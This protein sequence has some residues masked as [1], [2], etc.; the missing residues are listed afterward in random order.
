[1]IERAKI[2]IIEDESIVAEDLKEVLEK[3]GYIVPAILSSG[4]EALAVV[5]T[6]HPDLILMD[7]SLSGRLDGIETAKRIHEKYNIP[8]IYLTSY[9]SDGY[10][11]S[12]K[13]T[14][15]YGYIVK[16]FDP[17]SIS[18]TIEIALHKH[19]I[20]TRNKISLD[21][22]RF[23]AEYTSSWEMW[24][25][26]SGSPL[27]ISPSCERITGY[28]P[29]EIIAHPRLLQDMVFS[30]DRHIY[31]DHVACAVCSPNQCDRVNFRIVTRSGDVRWIG[32]SCV[33]IRDKQGAV[34]GKRISNADITSEQ[35]Q[36]HDFALAFQESNERFLLLTETMADTI[37][38]VY[39]EA[40][41]LEYINRKGASL[42]GKNPEELLN[43]KIPDL[44]EPKIAKNAENILESF[45]TTGKPAFVEHSYIRCPGDELFFETWLFSLDQ[46]SKK[47][48][49]VWGLM[50]DISDKKRAEKDLLE[51]LKEKDVMLKEIHH[52]V[53]N[54]LQQ[55]ASLLYLQEI[56]GNN[57]DIVTALHESR[58]RIFS[59]ALV[60]EILIASENLSQINLATYLSSLVQ[61]I[62][63]S[64]GILADLVKVTMNVDPAIVLT[65][66]ECI[67]CG[68]II[69]ELVSNSMKHA[70]LPGMKGEIFIRVSST[71]PTCTLIV[72]DN[73]RGLPSSVDT[74]R[75]GS[76][77]LQLVARLVHQLNGSMSVAGEHGTVYT[78]TFPMNLPGCREPS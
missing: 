78:I 18:T 32:H 36:I 59:M 2:L 12:A 47:T 10:I 44:F 21:T 1:M 74:A 19:A 25:D 60:H 16:P 68:L 11:E 9:S 14:D 66:D 67:P 33:L 72:G 64:Y 35:E 8:V 61:H 28:K 26:A 42:L 13:Q 49:K 77:G 54:N 46:K 53:K 22:Y 50:H 30:E 76:L 43:K 73:G 65:L 48:R 24:L 7:I 23:I 31:A 45:F 6:S 4:E 62:E 27:Y 5:S 38:F 58:D 17:P 75:A 37:I 57:S 56:R 63:G 29:A 39:D 34:I 52:R 3:K 20:D 71:G 51:S 70:F 40:H 41:G 69:N 55:V 15:P